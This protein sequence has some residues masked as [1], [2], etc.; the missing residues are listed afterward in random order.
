MF[1]QDASTCLRSL[2]TDSFLRGFQSFFYLVF[3]LIFAYIFLNPGHSAIPGQVYGSFFLVPYLDLALAILVFASI[4][5]NFYETKYSE[6]SRTRKGVA[7]FLLCS[8]ILALLLA[9]F[10]IGEYVLLFFFALSLAKDSQVIIFREDSGDA[11]EVYRKTY[12]LPALITIAALLIYALI[13]FAG[14][15][16]ASQEAIS[17]FEGI[18][19][20]FWVAVWFISAIYR[21]A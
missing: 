19:T 3:L 18:F 2:G 14:P 8:L 16:F 20:N 9:F 10:A 12:L 6:E 1:L 7:A 11:H 4:E 15:S 21:R 13:A 17:S 5:T